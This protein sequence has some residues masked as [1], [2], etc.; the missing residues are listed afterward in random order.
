MEKG[1]HI[2]NKWRL[3]F[4]AFQLVPVDG[5]EPWMMSNIL[6][7][8][9]IRSAPQPLVHVAFNKLYHRQNDGSR[10]VSEKKTYPSQRCY[11]VLTDELTG[12]LRERQRV[13]E[14][15]VGHLLRISTVERTFVE[16]ELVG[17]D[18]QAPPVNLPGIPLPAHDLGCHVSHAAGYAGV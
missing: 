13:L 3:T 7:A 18:A 15:G 14:N 9:T 1:T 5:L 10:K 12:I 8:L 2:R 11:T 4:F 6:N 16:Q 17:S